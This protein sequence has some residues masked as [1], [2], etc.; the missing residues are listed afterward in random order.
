[1]L[2]SKLRF[3]NEFL[4]LGFNNEKINYEDKKKKQIEKKEEEKQKEI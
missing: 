3:N 1:L 2:L 4:E